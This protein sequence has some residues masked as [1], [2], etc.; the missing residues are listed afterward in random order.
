MDNNIYMKRLQSGLLKHPSYV[1]ADYAGEHADILAVASRSAFSVGFLGETAVKNGNPQACVATAE[2][3]EDR[4]GMMPER[5]SS[6]QLY[7]TQSIKAKNRRQNRRQRQ[8]RLT[9]PQPVN[10]VPRAHS[11]LRGFCVTK[12]VASGAVTEEVICSRGA[13]NTS[14]CSTFNVWSG[15]WLY[16]LSFCF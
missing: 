12:P 5:G 15:E 10:P 3:R 13:R 11:T 6:R 2:P 1:F 9:T 16:R 8:A 4:G 7:D 14:R